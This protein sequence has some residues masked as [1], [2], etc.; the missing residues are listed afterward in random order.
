MKKDQKMAETEV[1][2]VDPQTGG[3]KGR[4][5]EE[6]GAI[7][8]RA[9]MALA[10]VAGFGGR[11]YARSNYLR[12]YKW[13]LSYDALM[14]H[15]HAFWSGENIDPESQCR[16]M[17][18]VAWHALALVSFEMHGLGTDDRWIAPVKEREGEFEN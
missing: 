14:R 11:K 3:A 2:E 5:L 18:S 9:L 15:A 17:A 10:A 12:G 6:L 4:K 16:H 13:S 8:P 1:R 7:D